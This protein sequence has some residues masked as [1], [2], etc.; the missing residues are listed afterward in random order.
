M[1]QSQSH[2]SLQQVA[3]LTEDLQ[4][5][6]QLP[7]FEPPEIKTTGEMIVPV[8]RRA[9]QYLCLPSSMFESRL[10]ERILVENALWSNHYV[11]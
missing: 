3:R 9:D 5:I 8:R 10:E 6:A 4:S 7:I 2:A 11:D 1:G